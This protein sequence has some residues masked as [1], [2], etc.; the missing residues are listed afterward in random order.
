MISYI[1]EN[2]ETS[3]REHVNSEIDKMSDATNTFN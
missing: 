1:K 2:N 3:N